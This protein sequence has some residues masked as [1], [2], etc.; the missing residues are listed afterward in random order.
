[1]LPAFKPK[2]EPPP[3]RKSSMQ[4]ERKIV[5]FVIHFLSSPLLTTKDPSKIQKPLNSKY[6][7]PKPISNANERNEDTDQPGSRHEV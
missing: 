4:S 7:H 3:T 1:M 5:T 6:P 2:S